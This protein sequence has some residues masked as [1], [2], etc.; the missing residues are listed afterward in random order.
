MS[1]EIKHADPELRR[2]TFV[3]LGAASLAAIVLIWWFNGWLDRSTGTM[4]QDLL[5]AK[6]RVT[7]GLTCVACSLCLLILAGYAARLARGIVAERRWPL[8]TT[9]VVRD[10][11]IRRDD[12]ALAIARQLNIVAILLIVV[13]LGVCVISARQ[14]GVL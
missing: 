1:R 3:V 10:T 2:R 8:S 9:R 12:A 6:L 5:G 11:Q 7:I 14:F 4:P 13:A